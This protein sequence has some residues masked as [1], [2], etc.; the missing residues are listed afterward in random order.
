MNSIRWNPSTPGAPPA[1]RFRIGD[2]PQTW[3]DD[4][5]RAWRNAPDGGPGLWKA[6]WQL[7]QGFLATLFAT[8]HWPT[9]PP[10]DEEQG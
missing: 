3:E 6:G 1:S 8:R 2:G 9:R 7:S 4:M 5:E 10:E